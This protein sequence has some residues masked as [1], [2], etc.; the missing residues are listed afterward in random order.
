MY[1]PS[2]RLEESRKRLRTSLIGKFLGG[3]PPYHVIAREVAAKWQFNFNARVSI[4]EMAG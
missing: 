4:T 3:P 2:A 1:I